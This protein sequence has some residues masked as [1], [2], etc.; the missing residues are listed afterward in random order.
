MVCPFFV[1]FPGDGG[2]NITIAI[3]YFFA[4]LMCVT[5]ERE[6]YDIAWEISGGPPPLLCVVVFL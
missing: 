1:I 4:R 3:F 2:W 6:R 5:Y